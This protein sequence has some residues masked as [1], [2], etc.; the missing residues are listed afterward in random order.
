L[1]DDDK[2]YVLK[3]GNRGLLCTVLKL[4]HYEC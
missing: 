2:T 4:V 1:G 3:L